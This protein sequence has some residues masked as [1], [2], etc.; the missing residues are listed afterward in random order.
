LRKRLTKC[1]YA[2]AVGFF[3]CYSFAEESS[4]SCCAHGRHPHDG[5]FQ[6]TSPPEAF[7]TYLKVALVAASPGQPLHLLSD[8]AFI[9]PGST[10]TSASGSSRS[11]RH[12]RALRD[13]ALFGSSWS[14]VRLRVLRQLRQREDPVHPKLNEYTRLSATSAGLRVV[15][16]MPL[17][18]LILA[19]SASSPPRS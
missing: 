16:E 13:R 6:Y 3:A 12:G 15:F 17:F 19:R 18:M 5:H 9:S 4:T 1:V 8:L 14:F 7:F 11:P 10:S 2:V